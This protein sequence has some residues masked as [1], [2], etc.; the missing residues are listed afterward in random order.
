MSEQSKK[1]ASPLPAY[2]VFVSSTYSDMVY[3]MEWKDL[4]QTVYRHSKN[5]MRS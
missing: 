2:R 1:L 5:A 4:V 3:H